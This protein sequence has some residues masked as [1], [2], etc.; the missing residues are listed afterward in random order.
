V[1]KT[2]LAD[3]SQGGKTLKEQQVLPTVILPLEQEWRL[4]P[5]GL[6]TSGEEMVGHTYGW[7]RRN[8]DR[9][10]AW[11]IGSQKASV[12]FDARRMTALADAGVPIDSETSG[13]YLSL[14]RYV[15]D[16]PT[17]TIRRPVFTQTGWY[18]M[19]DG[20]LAF[21]LGHH[22][23]LADGEE[24]A[25]PANTSSQEEGAAWQQALDPGTRQALAAYRRSG[26][27]DISVRLFLDVV[28]RYPRVAAMAGM[29]Y[30]SLLLSFLHSAGAI[31]MA[32]YVVECT[33]DTTSV[34]KS[35]A[36]KLVLSLGGSPLELLNSFWRTGVSTGT[37]LAA[38]HCLPLGMEESHMAEMN[39]AGTEREGATLAALVYAVSQG[40]DRARGAAAGGNRE[41]K[42][43]R[44]VM[45]ITAERSVL[46]YRV[47]YQGEEQ[48]VIRVGLPFGVPDPATGR[49]VTGVLEP[50]VCHHYGHLIPE[51]VRSLLMRA[52][53]LG[54]FHKLAA[55]LVPE[56]RAE[57]ERVAA[58]WTATGDPE[59]DSRLG[60]FSKQA[61]A[62]MMMLRLILRCCGLPEREVDA[63]AAAARRALMEDNTPALSRDTNAQ[64]HLDALREIIATHSARIAGLEPVDRSGDRRVPAQG[65]IGGLANIHRDGQVWRVI[66]LLPDALDVLMADAIG[67][68]YNQQGFVQAMQRAG[69]WIGDPKKPNTNAVVKYVRA[70]GQT[71]LARHH[72][73]LLD[74]VWMD[75]EGP[76]PGR[77]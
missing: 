28:R 64:R 70:D 16:L 55:A 24:R 75:G 38:S 57:A 61:G 10:G 46:A 71:I 54:G 60:R 44:T 56:L 18:E 69:A 48:R 8:A 20:R 76:T 26:D 68:A 27:R 6:P 15:R 3:D 41:T 59:V 39:M 49:W 23:I 7:W 19:P 2:V 11:I 9:S 32:G 65:Y 12:L 51:V 77:A 67:A 62:G 36:Q 74:K 73:L 50:T 42:H 43:F 37:S 25:G 34:G 31:D 1:T 58:L 33:S 4:P 22:V 14:M 35:A 40:T 47:K 30:S 29:A 21:A 17:G 45:F 63:I 13:E 52:C 5:W 72:C 53:D 66:A